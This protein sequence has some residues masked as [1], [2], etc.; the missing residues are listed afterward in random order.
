[1]PDNPESKRKP[2]GDPAGDP[3]AKGHGVIGTEWLTDPRPD[4]FNKHVI[5]GEKV[6]AQIALDELE[7]FGGDANI[8]FKQWFETLS[9]EDKSEYGL[10]VKGGL[11]ELLED[12]IQ[13]AGFGGSVVG[14]MERGAFAHRD[15]PPGTFGDLRIE[16]EADN[17]HVNISVERYETRKPNGQCPDGITLTAHVRVKGGVARLRYKLY[18]P[19][20]EPDG[21][22]FDWYSGLWWQRND[23]RIPPFCY[24]VCS[25]EDPNGRW[26]KEDR[27]VSVE[28]IA[29]LGELLERAESH[30]HDGAKY[31][32]RYADHSRDGL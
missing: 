20:E 13:K 23:R 9:D 7:A 4:S 11:N 15:V 19:G 3:S 27:P 24:V 32:P 16:S 30:Q 28:E 21:K 18:D 29:V 31:G 10:R 6:E 25:V 5:S 14:L 12:L 1:M 26:S 8:K 17:S 2:A 22:A